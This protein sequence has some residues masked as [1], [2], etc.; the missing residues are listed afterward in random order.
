[1]RVPGCTEV[2][3]G[4]YRLNSVVGHTTVGNT[5][6]PDTSVRHAS[7][8]SEV[9]NSLQTD[10]ITGV[11]TTTPGQADPQLQATSAAPIIAED[12]SRPTE[13][14]GRSG[15]SYRYLPGRGTGPNDPAAHL[16]TPDTVTHDQLFDVVTDMRHSHPPCSGDRHSGHSLHIRK[17]ISPP[18]A[19]LNGD[20]KPVP[21]YGIECH[22]GTY[23]DFVEGINANST[24]TPAGMPLPCWD[25]DVVDQRRAEWPLPLAIKDMYPNLALIYTVVAKSGLP[26]ALGAKI[27]VPSGLK[28]EAWKRMA[29]GHYN[30]KVVLDGISYGFNLQYAGPPIPT[31]EDTVN[32]QSALAF[33]RQVREY[34]TTE[35]NEGAML[36][37]FYTPP[38]TWIHTSPLMTRPKA[39]V[40]PEARRII[41]DLSYPPDNN[42]NM[43]I[44]ANV[45]YG[46][47]YVHRLPTI[48]D[49]INVARMDEFQGWLFS[50][51][52]ARAYRNFPIDPID[53]P[54]T[55]I[56]FDGATLIDR[57][58][59]FGARSSSL[60][61]TMVAEYITRFL[62]T[63]GIKTLIYLDDLIGYTSD[64]QEAQRQYQAVVRVM[65]DLGLPLAQN[66]MTPPTKCITWLGIRINFVDKTL[67][68]PQEKVEETLKDFDKLS[69]RRAMSTKDLQSIAGRIN[70]IGKACRPARL[71]MARI[72]AYL[73][74]H[75]QGYTTVPNS[76]KADLRW[77]VEFLPHYNGISVIPSAQ[78]AFS[79]EADSCLKG[80]GALGDGHC[81]MFEYQPPLS[82]GHISQLEAVN[83]MAAIR[84]LLG[85]RHAGQT[86][87]VECDNSAAVSIFATGKG[88]EGV[89]LACARAIWRHSVDLDCH[90][91]FKHTPGVLMHAADTLSRA[92]LSA[93]HES[94]A[95]NLVRERNLIVTK[96]DPEMF[97][98]DHFL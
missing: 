23:N 53:W 39:A 24:P 33:P 8:A 45:I 76:V 96:A 81:Y 84:I 52:I 7:P 80:G 93:A 32:H 42:V 5:N 73:R 82:E 48:D 86:V 72:L 38:F 91:I 46:E 6:K 92:C 66:K 94:A 85:Q 43:A 77:F 17:S 27:L 15:G 30:D 29:T 18:L 19:Q 68:I 26:N 98:F 63:Q 61:M 9:H 59:P 22:A 50:I 65:E 54:I 21:D 88:R 25:A 4:G 90:L 44:A 12:Y 78:P 35:L 41:V 49:V 75:P 95:W 37:P 55:A 62:A 79:I 60:H 40:D 67:S 2:S 51:D 74:G 70:H 1:M 11:P 71:F 89:I 14:D 20:R 3:S 47:H 69:K 56:T 16:V 57:A 31:V 64:L 34:I 10:Y 58:M 36:G 13:T 87:M 83:C 28:R 97:N